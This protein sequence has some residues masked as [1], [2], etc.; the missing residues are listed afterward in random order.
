MPVAGSAGWSLLSL[1][2][3]ADDDATVLSSSDIRHNGYTFQVSNNRS[4][5]IYRDDKAAGTSAQLANTTAGADLT[6]GTVYTLRAV[7]TATQITVSI[8]EIAGLATTVTDSTYRVPWSVYVGRNFNAAATGLINIH[9][10]S[11]P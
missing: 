11:T 1:H 10:I 2:L 8:V 7:V 9:S 3:G 5:R 6:A 4:L